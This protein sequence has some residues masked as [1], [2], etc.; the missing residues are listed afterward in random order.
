MLSKKESQEAL[1]KLF[2][3]YLV[4]DISALYKT[5][6]TNS[7]MSVFRRLRDIE[8]ISSYTHAGRYYT[9]AAIP[10]YDVNGLWFF[11]EKGFSRFG[12]LRATIVEVVNASAL[13]M[14]YSQLRHLLGVT[15]QKALISLVCAEQIG[16]RK[17]HGMYL[18]VSAD[19]ERAS[20]QL[21][22]HQARAQPPKAFAYSYSDGSACRDD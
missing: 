3:Q 8:Y 11:Q 14:T 10:Q 16:R 17:I 5:L 6:E 12:T 7:R 13:G 1:R 22:Q 18:Y 4:V 15:V 20:K 19:P 2:H 21:S 9:L